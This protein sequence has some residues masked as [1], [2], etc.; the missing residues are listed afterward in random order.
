MVAHDAGTVL[1]ALS[2]TMRLFWG[3]NFHVTRNSLAKSL[4]LI[5][6]ARPTRFG[7]RGPAVCLEMH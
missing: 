4:G 5:D 1:L 6:S 3:T 2:C 7:S